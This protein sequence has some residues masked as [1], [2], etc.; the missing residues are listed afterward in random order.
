MDTNEEYKQVVECCQRALRG[1]FKEDEL[2]AIK[3]AALALLI[4]DFAPFNIKCT[5]IDPLL[6][7]SL[8]S[9]GQDKHS[10]HLVWPFLMVSDTKAKFLLEKV[11]IAIGTAIPAYPSG[12]LEIP[13][14]HSLRAPF[15]DKLRKDAPVPAGRPFKLQGC[16]SGQGHFLRPYHDLSPTYPF[17]DENDNLTE[18]QFQKAVWALT[19]LR[20][21][22][23]LDEMRKGEEDEPALQPPPAA[24]AETALTPASLWYRDYHD[25]SA[26]RLD[27]II[28]ELP[29]GASNE[30]KEEA[31]MKYMNSVCAVCSF[32]DLGII[33]KQYG[34][35]NFCEMNFV[36]FKAA[37]DFMNCPIIEFETPVQKKNKYGEVH[38]ETRT[39][40]KTPYQVWMQNPKRRTVT[41]VVFEPDP[42]VKVPDTVVNTWVGLRYSGDPL[43]TCIPSLSYTY[44]DFGLPEFFDHCFNVLCGK[45]EPSF[46]YLM[47]WMAH[48]VQK[49][50]VAT[51]SSVICAGNEGCGKS[52]VFEAFGH[53]LGRHF[54]C[55]HNIDDVVGRFNS[56]IEGKLFVLVNEMDQLDRQQN[57]AFKSTI[58][59]KCKRTEK[60]F[61]TPRFTNQ[62]LN[63]AATTNR[64]HDDIL[65]IGAQSRRYLMLLARPYLGH[66]N[67]AYFDKFANWLKG[68]GETSGYKALHYTLLKMDLTGFQPRDVPCT[69]ML[70]QH[71]LA[72]MDDVHSCFYEWMARNQVI[73]KT[74]DSF[75]E[76][77]WEEGG[78]GAL[79]IKEYDLFTAYQN[80]C[81]GCRRRPD[82]VNRFL[83]KLQQVVTIKKGMVDEPCF[84]AWKPN[85]FSA[86]APAPPATKPVAYLMFPPIKECMT[87]FANLYTNIELQLFFDQGVDDGEWK[88]APTDKFNFQDDEATPFPHA[89]HEEEFDPFIAPLF[90]EDPSTS[91]EEDNVDGVMSNLLPDSPMQNLL[92]DE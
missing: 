21:T 45:H 18:E 66:C 80:W 68:A 79:L 42:S 43:N 77:K 54:L 89:V 9:R 38:E 87:Q 57:A 84:S 65:K 7:V 88:P 73:S 32:N 92:G 91:D 6:L 69:K 11:K 5:E 44:G 4:E 85:D 64:P 33:L 24:A 81:S 27:S 47:K 53:L 14:C 13:A 19:S 50:E 40:K 36:S 10:Y 48:I 17:P 26:S 3:E 76:Y 23:Y 2:K 35:D 75:S 56:R 67:R 49:P 15:C 62:N 25:F 60:K 61:R 52:M 72:N 90:S 82:N 22:F 34:C 46:L 31:V 70:L 86:N 12:K 78:N 8:Q 41:G 39:T 16:Y 29:Q 63:V 71:K 58:T 74:A 59:D 55:T 51:A 20:F 37:Q 83:M 1:V 28:Q 30:D